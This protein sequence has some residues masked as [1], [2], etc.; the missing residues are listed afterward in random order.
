[1]WTPIEISYFTADKIYIFLCITGALYQVFEL[2]SSFLQFKV[3]TSVHLDY[4]SRTPDDILNICFDFHKIFDIQKYFKLYPSLNTSF[5]DA[6]NQKNWDAIYRL[7]DKVSV[8]DIISYTVSISDAISYCML[9]NASNI[10][11]V[12]YFYG[13]ECLNHMKVSKYVSNYHICYQFKLLNVMDNYDDGVLA[14]DPVEPR[15]VNQIA[16]NDSKFARVSNFLAFYTSK[17]S[18]AS[19]SEEL[20]QSTL[21]D[22]ALDKDG[23]PLFNSFGVRYYNTDIQ[24]LEAPYET[25]CRTYN[26]RDLFLE[27]VNQA[28]IDTFGR[29]S[30]MSQHWNGT[31]RLLS[32]KLLIDPALDMKYVNICIKC[33]NIFKWNDCNFNLITSSNDERLKWEYFIIYSIFPDT[34]DTRIGNRPRLTFLDYVILCTSCFGTWTGVSFMALNPF[35]NRH[36]KVE[37]NQ[38]MIEICKL[39]RQMATQNMVNNLLFD[40][41]KHH[42]QIINHE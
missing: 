37:S 6:N 40:V 13:D 9:R 42:Q 28:V 2:S 11:T 15:S 8:D 19:A 29:L 10:S 27:C 23:I 36:R 26:K 39:R 14:F 16:L 32:Y 30:P 7:R 25:N 5:E 24:R 21:L 4:S 22:R 41:L 20:I 3:S 1:M 18:S 31:R 35:K 38:S 12:N 17:K 34:V 33:M